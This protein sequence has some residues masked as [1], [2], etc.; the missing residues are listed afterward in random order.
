MSSID[1][2]NVFLTGRLGADPELKKSATGA[3]YV[4]LSMAVHKPTRDKTDQT[5]WYKVM[6]WGNEA[7]RCS[8]MLR[9]GS[10]ILVQGHLDS[11]SYESEG[12]K[13]N[14]VQVVSH[15]WQLLGS[16]FRAAVAEKDADVQAVEH[17]PEMGAAPEG[18]MAH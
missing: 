10:F 13:R 15:R 18:V 3:P 4:R 8:N 1:T 16:G 11:Y 2:N 5:Q 9:K 6:V 7:E 12:A 14:V 17:L